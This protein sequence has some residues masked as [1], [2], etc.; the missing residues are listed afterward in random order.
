M[1]LLS[2]TMSVLNEPEM[3]QIWQAALRVWARVP[4]RVQ[5]TE[6]FLQPLRDFGC[7]IDGERVSF[8]ETV[9]DRVLARVERS[10]EERGPC[11]PA[12][13]TSNQL[14][15]SA[16][17]QALVCC[18]LDTEALRPATTHDL[19][20]WSWICDSFPRLGRSHPTFI[21]QD[22]PPQICDLH[23][24]ATNILNSRRATTV[25]VYNADLLPYFLELQAISSG[26]VAEAKR[27][28]A[29]VAKCWV[30][31]PFMITRENIE[32][33]LRAR[34][35]LGQ[36]FNMMTMPVTGTATPVT[37]AGALVQ[38]TAEVLACNVISLALDD[39]LIG[40]IAH[41]CPFDMRVGIHTQS[42]PDMDV[43]ALGARQMGAYAFGGEF[44]GFGGPGTA[45]KTPGEQALMEKALA[46][47]W[48]ICGGVRGWGS[49]GVTAFSDVGSIT[50]LI[51]DLEL[52]SYF[53]RLLQGIAVDAEK[54]AEEVICEIAPQGAYFLNQE[55]TARHFREELWLPELVDRRVPMAWAQEPRTMLDNARAKAKRVAAEAVNH[56][57][58][59]DEQK[60]Q[61]A[62]IM[63]EAGRA[64]G[65]V[66]PA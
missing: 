54:L 2:H 8:P 47:M 44:M 13:V 50:Q 11:R 18:D 24:F 37:M 9:R 12:Q 6:E 58:L 63:A 45:A 48:G 5:G 17:G 66:L 26:S 34:E 59:T 57:P 42:G 31:T 29:F 60:R 27:A 15:Y 56:C 4:L 41:P 46:C 36:P 7:Q 61:V 64:V 28:P 55:H 10:R 21:P 62:A 35:L 16:S 65:V 33:G 3:E 14:S 49:L 43:L 52:M 40:W 25:S 1:H 38:C 30:N 23:A 39:R 51:L 19:A 32:V 20:Q 22:V 53:E